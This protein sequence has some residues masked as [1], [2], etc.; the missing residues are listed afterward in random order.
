M[1]FKEAKYNLPTKFLNT[2]KVYTIFYV[3]KADVELVVLY[4][5]RSTAAIMPLKWY[6]RR[7]SFALILTLLYQVLGE[8]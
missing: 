1:Q 7:K 3:H 2:L 8:G 6:G 4:S 5:S